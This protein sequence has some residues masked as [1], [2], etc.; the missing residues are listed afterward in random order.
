MREIKFRAWDRKGKC[1]VDWGCMRQTAF[2]TQSIADQHRATS[3]YSPFFYRMFNNPDIELM[4]YTGLKDKNGKDIYE[5][6]ILKHN[7]DDDDWNDSVMWWD[8]MARFELASLVDYPLE[9]V[10]EKFKTDPL[11]I[12]GRLDPMARAKDNRDCT[13]FRLDSVTLGSDNPSIVIGNIYENPELINKE[14]L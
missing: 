1:M 6:D 3:I 12:L 5:G 9:D 14:E 7:P 4:Q 8:E 10:A 13:M 2:N 11:T